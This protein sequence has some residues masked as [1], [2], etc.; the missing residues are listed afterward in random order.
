MEVATAASPRN[1]STMKRHLGHTEVVR[2]HME[3]ALTVGR[4]P[5]EAAL[6][7]I[8]DQKVRP[9]FSLATS[10]IILFSFFAPPVAPMCS[11]VHFSR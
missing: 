1:H 3:A 6:R 10:S 8:M 4:I 2:V 9:G 7:V 11:L 5:M